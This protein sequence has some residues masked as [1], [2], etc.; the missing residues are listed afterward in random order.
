MDSCVTRIRIKRHTLCRVR[1]L[2]VPGVGQRISPYCFVSEN[3]TGV[4]IL[5]YLFYFFLKYINVYHNSRT[6]AATTRISSIRAQTTLASAL[7][8]PLGKKVPL[9]RD[10]GRDFAR[11]YTLLRP[12]RTRRYS[13]LLC[14]GRAGPVGRP[15]GEKSERRRSKR[16]AVRNGLFRNYAR[17]SRALHKGRRRVACPGFAF[18]F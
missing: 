8:P 4:S 11:R 1:Y 16:R 9:P 14:R 18:A 7:S 3:I 2:M 13:P 17:P 6:R 10:R 12:R 5:L 15:A